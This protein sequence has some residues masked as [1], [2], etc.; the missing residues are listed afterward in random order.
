MEDRLLSSYNITDTS[1]VLII[2]AIR[3]GGIT[4]I[5]IIN[6]LG[7]VLYIFNLEEKKKNPSNFP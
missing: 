3:G 7:E 6:F 4:P 5:E 1:T 2:N